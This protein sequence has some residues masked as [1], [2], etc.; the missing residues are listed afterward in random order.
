MCAVMLVGLSFHT[1]PPPYWCQDSDGNYI[2][3]NPDGSA[4]TPCNPEANTKVYEGSACACEAFTTSSLCAHGHNSY[5]LSLSRL[6]VCIR[7][8]HILGAFF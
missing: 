4:A 3:E 2:E 1:I 7:A 8:T 5:S 6:V